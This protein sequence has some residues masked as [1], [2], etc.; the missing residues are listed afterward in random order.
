MDKLNN[1]ES[2]K[3]LAVVLCWN[4]KDIIKSCVDSLLS[5]TEKPEILVVDNGSSDGSYQFLEKEY[6]TKIKLVKNPKI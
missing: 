1:L 6:G 4:N 3:I 2:K 5:Q